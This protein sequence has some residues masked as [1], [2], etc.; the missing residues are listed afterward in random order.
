MWAY[1]VMTAVLCHHARIAPD[2]EPW[3]RPFGT[4]DIA[5]P[6]VAA[7]MR[8]LVVLT[9]RM[10]LIQTHQYLQCRKV[11]AT[12]TLKWTTIVSVR[13]ACKAARHSWQSFVTAHRCFNVRF[14]LMFLCI[15]ELQNSIRT[16]CSTI[17]ARVIR[18]CV[19][20]G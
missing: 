16:M 15:A 17:S 11:A 12:N 2:I 14:E 4:T 20:H 18:R 13:A 1:S 19:D 5:A 7:K 8:N 9:I 6:S 3:C 10:L